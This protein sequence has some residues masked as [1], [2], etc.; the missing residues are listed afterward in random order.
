MYFDIYI[1]SR[2]KHVKTIIGDRTNIAQLREKLS[3]E[4]FDVIFDNSGRKLTDTKPL[5][6]IFKNRLRQFIYMSSAGVYL[7]SD[8]MPY[9]EGDAI[10]PKSRHFGTVWILC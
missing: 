8:E 2:L 9:M 5:T 6:M 1:V 7:N 3:T 10:D 4:N